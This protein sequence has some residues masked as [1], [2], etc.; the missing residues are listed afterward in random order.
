MSNYLSHQGFKIYYEVT[1]SPLDEN[2]VLIHG[3]L[4]SRLWWHPLIDVW[5]QNKSGKGVVL[6]LDWRG[7][8]RSKG[9]KS[10]EEIDFHVYA[11]DIV[12][13]MNHFNLKQKWHLS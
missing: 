6:N 10:E 1:A 12:A 8:G 4:A 13:L 9:L 7:Y 2:I 11:S 5:S 3:N